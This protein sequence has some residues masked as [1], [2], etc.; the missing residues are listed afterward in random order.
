MIDAWVVADCRVAAQIAEAELG[1]P[2]GLL[3]AIS[4]VESSHD[5]LVVRTRQGVTRARDHGTAY[6]VVL[7]A[8]H[9]GDRPDAGCFQIN[10]Y[11]H[12]AAFG[13]VGALM[14]PMLQARYAGR[15]LLQLRAE[16]GNWTAAVAAYHS[17]E[18]ERGTSYVCRVAAAWRG[19]VARC[20]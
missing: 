4:A 1:L 19:E 14:D 7:Q 12:G 10:G 11:W 9:A 17:R 3:V 5:P 15:F 16:F 2:A 8:L 13:T 20:D 6:R 18:R